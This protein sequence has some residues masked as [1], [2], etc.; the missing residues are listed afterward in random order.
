MLTAAA[1][2]DEALGDGLR[3]RGAGLAARR[4]RRLLDAEAVL[5]A[6]LDGPPTL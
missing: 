6:D 4:L 2:V 3:G 1:E 5:L